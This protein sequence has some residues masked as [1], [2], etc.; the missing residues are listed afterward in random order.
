MAETLYGRIFSQFQR[1]CNRDATA[2]Q[3][4]KIIRGFNSI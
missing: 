4:N 1:L 3:D 2:T